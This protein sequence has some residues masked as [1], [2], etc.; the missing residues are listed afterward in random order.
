MFRSRKSRTAATSNSD[1]SA[2]HHQ[3][4]DD[5][6]DDTSNGPS[7]SPSNNSSA[8]NLNSGNNLSHNEGNE[9]C[10]NGGGSRR[11]GK[12]KRHSVPINNNSSNEEAHDWRDNV[13]FDERE[14]VR[15]IDSKGK[16]QLWSG[17][18]QPHDVWFLEKGVRFE[19]PFNR[20]YQPIRK[21]GLVLVKF[22]S[23]IA[24]K[25]EICPIREVNWR[26]VNATKQGEIVELIRVR[27]NLSFLMVG[28][29]MMQCLGMLNMAKSKIDQLSAEITS[30][31]KPQE[32]IESEVFNE[33]MYDKDNTN[34]KSVGYGFGVKRSDVLGVHALL[35]KRGVT[36]GNNNIGDQNLKA[37]FARHKRQTT[38]L[39][40]RLTSH[41]T[42]FLGAVRDGNV[43]NEMLDSTC[44][45]LRSINAQTTGYEYYK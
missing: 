1:A 35:R 10:N 24:K 23:N 16:I 34:Q 45:A 32:E 21:G 30:T 18:I 15:A 2:H 9:A 19:V 7:Q 20:Y 6:T 36:S 4:I 28:Y 31:P 43:T 37:E 14:D 5:P 17:S 42:D 12:R 33:L 26:K 13:D 8:A 22:I 44:S 40:M 11:K 25:D 29:T 41:M 27:E 3:E 38:D 39:L